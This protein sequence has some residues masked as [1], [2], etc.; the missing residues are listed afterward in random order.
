[1]KYNSLCRGRIIPYTFNRLCQDTSESKDTKHQ[2][3]FSNLKKRKIEREPRIAI[4]VIITIIN[5]LMPQEQDPPDQ[6]SPPYVSRHYSRGPDWQNT[7][8]QPQ[9]LCESCWFL[10]SCSGTSQRFAV[11]QLGGCLQDISGRV[12]LLS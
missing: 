5:E 12:G 7:S 3:N 10:P 8:A 9:T 1:M 6:L 2:D 11:V 4:A